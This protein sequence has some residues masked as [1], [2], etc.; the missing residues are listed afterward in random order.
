[1]ANQNPNL[2]PKD[3]LNDCLSCEKSFT[4]LY[5]TA[6]NEVSNTQLRQDMLNILVEKH[7]CENNIF[8]MMQQRNMYQVKPADVQEIQ[9]AQQQFTQQQQM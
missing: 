9:Q 7:N 6:L 8:S 2:S 4:S 1:M 3:I 5:N